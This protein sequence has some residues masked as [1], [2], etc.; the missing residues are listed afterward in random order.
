MHYGILI[1][2]SYTIS[3]STMSPNFRIVSRMGKVEFC[4]LLSSLPLD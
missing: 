1:E 2:C 4:Y 3:E